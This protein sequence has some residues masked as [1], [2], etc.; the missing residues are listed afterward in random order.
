M[1]ILN[2]LRDQ[3][4]VMICQYLYWNGIRNVIRKKVNNCDTCQRK[5]QSNIKYGKLPFKEAREIPWNKLCV[6]LIGTYVIQRK[7][8]KGNINIK[9]VTMIYPVT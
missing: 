4:E 2:H 9:A 3:T 1:Y 6:Y 8:Q 5:K 7:G